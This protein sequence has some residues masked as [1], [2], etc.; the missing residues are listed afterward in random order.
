MP[1]I[2]IQGKDLHYTETDIVH[3]D[4]GLIGMPHLRRMVLINQS[5]IEPFFWLVSLDDPEAA[6]LVIDPRAYFPDYAPALP[7]EVPAR[8]GLAAGEAPLVLA[9]VRLTSD[10]MKSTINLRAPLLCAARRMRGAQV[11][12][13]QSAYRLNEPLPVEEAA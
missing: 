6:F 5:D 3:F 12:L 1:T 9:I 8:L 4:E 10:W 7:E 2:R 13:T 11:A